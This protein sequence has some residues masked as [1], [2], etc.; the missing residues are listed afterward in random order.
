MQIAAIIF[1]FIAVYAG[2]FSF[3]VVAAHAEDHADRY[4]RRVAQ[5]RTTLPAV[6]RISVNPR[7]TPVEVVRGH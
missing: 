6:W 4:K 3:C 5:A 1:T 2:L 7:M